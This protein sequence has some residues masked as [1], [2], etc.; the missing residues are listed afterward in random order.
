MDAY[1]PLT[2]VILPP[3]I[4]IGGPTRQKITGSKQGAWDPE[5]SVS[6]INA[7]RVPV[8]EGLDDIGI[9][10][11]NVVIHME[12]DG[13]SSW[14]KFL[15]EVRP[16][17]SVDQWMDWLTKSSSREEVPIFTDSFH[18]S[19]VQRNMIGGQTLTSSHGHSQ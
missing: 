14:L 8:D 5:I 19:L 12:C 7:V 18:Y 13:D 9:K 16:T 6:V 2:L 1:K 4:F 11:I 15:V 10:T 17:Q 3:V